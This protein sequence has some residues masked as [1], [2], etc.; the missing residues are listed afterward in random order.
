MRG[1]IPERDERRRV[2]RF[3]T[4]GFFGTND[5]LNNPVPIPLGITVSGFLTALTVLLAFFLLFFLLGI[6]TSTN[7]D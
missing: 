5:L 2:R 7:R 1:I 6:S 3:G 4:E